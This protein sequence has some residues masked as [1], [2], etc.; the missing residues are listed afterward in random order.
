MLFRNITPIVRV[1]MEEAFDLFY[2]GEGWMQRLHLSEILDGWQHSRYTD[3][4]HVAVI[5]G[6][7]YPMGPLRLALRTV[8]PKWSYAGS[9]P[10]LAAIDLLPP[11]EP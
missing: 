5:G 11:G 8:V 2:Y 1:Y 9:P 3:Q 4:G 7:E 10:K 6:V